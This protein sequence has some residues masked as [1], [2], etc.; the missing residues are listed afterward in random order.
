M[1]LSEFEMPSA[2]MGGKLVGENLAGGMDPGGT[3][4]C[5]VVSLARTAK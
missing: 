2:G 3:S 4:D 1:N 5:C